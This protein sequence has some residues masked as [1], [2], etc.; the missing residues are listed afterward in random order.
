MKTQH[1]HRFLWTAEKEA[2]T[3][4]MFKTPEPSLFLE[5]GSPKDVGKTVRSTELFSFLPEQVGQY[6]LTSSSSSSSLSSIPLE[7]HLEEMVSSL[8][9]K[10][11]KSSKAVESMENPQEGDAKSYRQGDP[12]PDYK[13][14]EKST[15]TESGKQSPATEDCSLMKTPQNEWKV[16]QKTETDLARYSAHKENQDLLS[17][18]SR[19]LPYAAFKGSYNKECFNPY[20][21]GNWRYGMNSAEM[22]PCHNPQEGNYDFNF[23][24]QQ[25]PE[26]E[27]EYE[28]RKLQSLI[29]YYKFSLNG[30]FGLIPIINSFTAQHKYLNGSKKRDFCPQIPKNLDNTV[31]YEVEFVEAKRWAIFQGVDVLKENGESLHSCLNEQIILEMDG[32]IDLAVLR[33]SSHILRLSIL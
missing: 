23:C 17:V 10:K 18:S 7:S 16:N 33:V 4:L 2:S 5:S 15:N 19:S 11:C 22:K 27:H 25:E 14:S 24:A 21:G 13:V 3:T 6:D 30:G 28:R 26:A 32:G 1:K 12:K 20:K 31:L 29:S 8:I 9:G